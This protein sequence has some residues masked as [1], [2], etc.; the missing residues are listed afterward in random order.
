[1]FIRK[2]KCISPF[3]SM[4][5]EI[6]CILSESIKWNM[7]V[8]GAGKQ[9]RTALASNSGGERNNEH[10]LRWPENWWFPPFGR[11]FPFAGH[12]VGR[13]VGRSLGQS[14]LLT[15]RQSQTVWFCFLHTHTQSSNTHWIL[16]TTHTHWHLVVCINEIEQQQQYEREIEKKTNFLFPSILNLSIRIRSVIAFLSICS[17]CHRRANGNTQTH[18]KKV[19]A[20]ANCLADGIED[21]HSTAQQSRRVNTGPDFGMARHSSISTFFASTMD[22]LLCWIRIFPHRT[23][24]YVSVCVICWIFAQY[25]VL[26]S[27]T[28]TSTSLNIFVC[29]RFVPAL[30]LF[31]LMLAL[32]KTK[33]IERKLHKSNYQLAGG[34]K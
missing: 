4:F 21:E 33:N 23:Y 15:G 2:T 6:V 24:Q 20:H 3:H 5:V 14:L 8:F 27:I 34:M 13:S 7:D 1:M 9:W 17:A 18:T 30:C 32:I 12:T 25:L 10:A 29:S 19:H 26:R 11:E 31:I 16:Y 28:S 22:L